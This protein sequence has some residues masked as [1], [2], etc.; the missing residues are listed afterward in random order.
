MTAS[1]IKTKQNKTKQNKTKQK[2]TE[3]KIEIKVPSLR[4]VSLLHLHHLSDIWSTQ[5]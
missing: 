4:S 2:K 1:N 5:Q 3:Q